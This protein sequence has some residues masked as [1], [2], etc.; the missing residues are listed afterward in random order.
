MATDR[1]FA[2]AL[3]VAAVIGCD[4]PSGTT[5]P[6]ASA[7]SVEPAATGD[8]GADGEAQKAR[9]VLHADRALV[10]KTGQ[11]ISPAWVEIEGTTITRVASTPPADAANARE[12][13]DAT[14]MPG[15]IDA[16]SH[17]LHLEKADDG[18]SMVAEAVTMTDADRA[19]RGAKL[20]REMLRAG[21]TTVRDLGNSGRTGDVAL[22][23]AIDK[24]WVTGPT[25][26]VS[27]RALA[28]PGGQFPRLGP[29]FGALVEQEYVVVRSAD[30]GR[31]A[32]RQ[33]FYE[34]ADLIKIIVDH[35]P[36]RTMTAD[37]VKAV[38][39]AAHAAKK[40]VAAHVLTP[41]A[42]DVA[43]T[44]GVDSCDHAY[45]ISDATLSMMS[46]KRI[47]L[48]PTDYPGDYYEKF[49]PAGPK[50]DA[51][52]AHMKKFRERAIARL[53]LAKKLRVPIAA[54]SDAYVETEHDDRGKEAGLVFRAYAESG[55]SPLE[56]VQTATSNAAELLGLPDKATALD[57]G[58]P[59]DVIAVRGDP[60]KDAGALTQV[61]LVIKR[62]RVVER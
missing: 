1:P 44:A 25:M 17:L 9:I 4:K 35:G 62:G 34:G 11:I 55:L 33:A 61:T 45:D 32:V 5:A 60:T 49:A 58:S 14:I 42:A 8:G 7:A 59:A 56:I 37:E 54:G 18:S 30:E 21:F 28:P 48:V 12:L 13:G 39:D 20:A 2:L 24:G 16:H 6:D 29:A 23:R 51:V 36:G 22:K 40:K 27:T 26:L 57:K 38:V 10:P 43:V 46:T 31:A 15:L 3:A 52:L 41:E 50:H 47:F 19:L 53:A